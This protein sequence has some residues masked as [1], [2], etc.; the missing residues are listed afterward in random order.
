MQAGAL[1]I[2]IMPLSARTAGELDAALH[3]VQHHVGHAFIV[4][5][6]VLFIVNRDKIAEALRKAKVPLVVPTRD[7]RVDGV[8]MS[9]GS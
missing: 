1:H 7:Y 9:Y 5:S 3:A 8:L 4:T 6:D 2:E